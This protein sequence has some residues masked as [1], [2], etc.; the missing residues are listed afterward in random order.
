MNAI[1]SGV[2]RLAKEPPFRVFVR[3][4]LRRLPL[5]T[6]TRSIWDLSSR[7]A[8]LLGVRAA[9]VQARSQNVAAISVI[10]FGVAGGSGLVALETEA[11]AV[12]A[13]TG[14]EVLVFGF[15]M[16]SFGLPGFIGD[17]RDHPDVWKPGD[18]P[19][20][21]MAL[22]AKLASR[23]ELILGNV[24]QSAIDFVERRKSPPV[25]FVSIDLDLYSST[26]DALRVLSHRDR[27]MLWHVP[28]YFDD[29][30]F[31]FNYRQAGEL[32]AI[33]EFNLESDDVK[34]DR[35][36]GVR[37]DRPFPERPY[38]DKLFVAHDLAA[39]SAAAVDRTRG[40]LPLKR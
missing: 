22:R 40:E 9:A 1:A 34:I 3:A 4:L 16:G 31:I 12:E 11:A 26:R 10:E 35:W 15:D 18:F 5:S 24:E 19:M 29:I 7:P 37:N 23:T 32:L 14:V 25:G 36:Y 38:L 6:S 17:H 21:E 2:V 20:D 28:L 33:E 30:D 8:Y 39:L 13:E 27:R